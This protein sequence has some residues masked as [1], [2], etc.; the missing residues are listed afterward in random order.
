MMSLFI[1]QPFSH[2]FGS[3]I[4]RPRVRWE[5]D[6]RRASERIGKAPATWMRAEDWTAKNGCEPWDRQ[7]TQSRNPLWYRQIKCRDVRMFGSC[8][9][10][11]A[12]LSELFYVNC[13][14]NWTIVILQAN[15]FYARFSYEYYGALKRKLIPVKDC[16]SG[17]IGGKRNYPFLQVI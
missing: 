6:P 12:K 4:E 14:H 9:H 13:F 10:V 11:P 17:S 7:G 8:G 2:V 16:N 5:D 1:C 15:D 3:V